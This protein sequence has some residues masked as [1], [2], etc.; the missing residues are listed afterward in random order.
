M[1][2][3]N[4]QTS[5]IVDMIYNNIYNKEY[6]AKLTKEKE[7]HIDNW[8]KLLKASTVYKSVTKALDLSLIQWVRVLDTQFYAAM[9]IEYPYS[10]STSCSYFNS[11]EEMLKDARWK[12]VNNYKEENRV[13]KNDIETKV[14]MSML[15][16]K[17]IDALIQSVSLSF[18]K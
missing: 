6:V 3:T 4:R 18:Q 14:I 7:T 15:N 12:L 8:I 13:S 16:A 17:D 5:I 1:R 2:L 10:W 9:W 11:T